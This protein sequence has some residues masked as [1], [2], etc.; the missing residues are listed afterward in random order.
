[1]TT[2]E[3][4][5]ARIANAAARRVARNGI[6]GLNIRSVIEEARTSTSRFHHFFGTKDNLITQIFTDGWRIINDS[7]IRKLLASIDLSTPVLLDLWVSVAEGVLAAHEKNPDLVEAATI[8]A[9]E[10]PVCDTELRTS[11]ENTSGY[12]DYQTMIQQLGRAM[13]KELS[14]DYTKEALIPIEYLIRSWFMRPA[15]LG[16]AVA[17]RKMQWELKLSIFR[18]MVSGLLQK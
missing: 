18:K 16:H 15:S 2:R 10:M 13:E 11:L 3:R 5:E 7:I 14:A 9:T 12:K 1:M 4:P 6:K 8:L 17:E